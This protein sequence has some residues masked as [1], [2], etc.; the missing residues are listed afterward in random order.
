MTRH[1]AEYT[2]YLWEVTKAMKTALG[3]IDHILSAV[4]Y[5][6]KLDDLRKPLDLHNVIYLLLHITVLMLAGGL[7]Y[8]LYL[9][10][11]LM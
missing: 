7:V 9:L 8:A 4:N 11:K 2:Q 1:S 6:R 3:V 10:G 5:F